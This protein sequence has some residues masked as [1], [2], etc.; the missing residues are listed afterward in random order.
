MSTDS[1]SVRLSVVTAEEVLRTI[2]GD[3]FKGCTVSLDKIAEIIC[4]GF[5]QREAAQADLVGLYEKVIEALHLLSTPP[6]K[7]K[8]TDPTELRTLLSERLDAIHALTTKTMQTTALAKPQGN[9]SVGAASPPE[10]GTGPQS[11]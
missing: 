4:G 2:Y 10:T 6:D 11:Q 8:V 7:S 3:D 5:R 9:T 1:Q